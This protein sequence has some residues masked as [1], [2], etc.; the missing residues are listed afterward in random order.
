MHLFQKA[1]EQVCLVVTTFPCWESASMPRLVGFPVW[2]TRMPSDCLDKR[3]ASLQ[4]VK[5]RGIEPRSEF[6]STYHRVADYTIGV[7]RPRTSK[8]QATFP[9]EAILLQKQVFA[10][11]AKTRLYQHLTSSSMLVHNAK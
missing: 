3:N 8:T 11:L 5:E 10:A 1:D 6:S 2:L 4:L 9:F 7:K